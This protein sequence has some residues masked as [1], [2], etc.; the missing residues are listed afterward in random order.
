ME[1][2]SNKKFTLVHFSP[3]SPHIDLRRRFPLT[4]FGA[5]GLRL[6]SIGKINDGV[7]KKT[8]NRFFRGL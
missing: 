7:R 2:A 4:L 8:R 1:F 5:L 6:S 3:S